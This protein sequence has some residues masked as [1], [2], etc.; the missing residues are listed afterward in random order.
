[1]IWQRLIADDIDVTTT[2]TDLVLQMI[3]DKSNLL[4]SFVSLYA[5]FVGALHRIIGIEFGMYAG[6]V[7]VKFVLTFLGAHF[8]HTLIMRYKNPAQ[9]STPIATIY[10][11]PDASKESLN[12]LTLVAELYNAGVVG[13]K[14]IYDLIRE[15]IDAGLR[16]ED[17]ER[18]LKLVKRQSS[19]RGCA[20][21]KLMIKAVDPS[22]A[23]R[24]R[25]V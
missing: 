1:M 12:L 24:I 16:E 25:V 22:C 11:T 20:V 4:D 18:L 19:R 14:L 2:I 6:S 23:P 17:V 21:S 3:S 7:S 10:E 5:T 9:T 13:P 15:L 8:L